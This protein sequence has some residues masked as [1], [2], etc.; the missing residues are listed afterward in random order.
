M[1]DLIRLQSM[2]P[3]GSAACR[4]SPLPDWA[5]HQASE[6][7]K[8]WPESCANQPVRDPSDRLSPATKNAFAG[9]SSIGP[10]RSCFDC[11]ST[12]SA[13]E[14]VVNSRARGSS[15]G[16]APFLVWESTAKLLLSRS[17]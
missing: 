8:Q 6:A 11:T 2:L 17:F 9:Q 3:G 16:I 1:N 5:E 7:R 10:W 13:V 14:K 4:L 15:D 12:K